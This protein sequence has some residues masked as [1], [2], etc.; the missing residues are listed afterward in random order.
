MQEGASPEKFGTSEAIS[1]NR[2]K[3]NASIILNTL[4]RWRVLHFGLEWS[5]LVLN[6]FCSFA[7]LVS[8]VYVPRS[9]WASIGWAVRLCSMSCVFEPAT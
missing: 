4:Q 2:D 1:A 7:L 8:C 5:V 9:E 3:D 6:T